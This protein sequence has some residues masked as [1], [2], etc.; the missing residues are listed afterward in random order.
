WKLDLEI[1]EGRGDNRRR[2]AGRSRVTVLGAPLTA[3]AMQRVAGRVAEA[4]GNIDRIVRL[5]KY[6][7]TAIELDVSGVDPAELRGVLAAAAADAGVDIAVQR[8]GLARRAK[9]LVVMDVDSTLIQDEVIE[10]LAR[11]AGCLEQVE[12]VTAEAMRGEMDFAASL[13][14]RVALLEGLPEAVFGKVRE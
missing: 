1:T 7:V 10:L 9:H 11:H 14:A 2:R 5:A 8:S 12:Q 4:Q 13:R 3:A 6:P